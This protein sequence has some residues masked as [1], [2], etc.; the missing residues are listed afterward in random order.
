M[1]VRPLTPVSL[2]AVPWNPDQDIPST[3]NAALG[4]QLHALFDAPDPSVVPSGV[5]HWF[6]DAEFPDGVT[7]VPVVT[8]QAW[9]TYYTR[10]ESAAL[11]PGI[12]PSLVS[13]T[14]L[15]NDCRADGP[16]P[17]AIANV[18]MSVV[19][20]EFSQRVLAAAIAGTGLDPAP[21]HLAQVTQPARAFMAAPLLHAQ[22]GMDVAT[23]RSRT[24]TFVIDERFY[25]SNPGAPLPDA[26]EVD[27]GDGKPVRVV[28]FGSRITAHYPTGDS[29]AIIVRCRYGDVT[30][31]ARTSIAISDT[32]T[33]P[34]P[35]D[36]WTLTGIP[37]GNTGTAYVWRAPGHP[38]VVNPV[39]VAEGF[40]GGYPYDYIHDCFS[41]NGLLDA[42]QAR[43]YDLVV[44]SFDN[45]SDQMQHNADVMVAAIGEALT[46][47]R[48]QN[49][50][51][52]PLV[53]GGV[54]MGGLIARYAL[55]LMEAHG[56][57]HGTRLFFSIDSPHSGAYT[58]V[59][60][61][62]LLQYLAPASS[63][64]ASLAALVNSPANQ[65]FMVSWV[66]GDSAIVSPLRTLFLR[67]LEGIGSWP[68]Q[69]PRLVAIANGRG[70]GQRSIAPNA[71]MLEWSGGPFA[72]AR[73]FALP[74]G[75]EPGLVGEAYCF[76]S[77]GS[78]PSR[79]TTTSAVSWEGAPGGL[80]IYN[81][82][83]AGVAQAVGIGALND[84]IPITLCIP[85][86][87]AVGMDLDTVNAF[88]PVPPPGSGAS[89]FHDYLCGTENTRHLTITPEAS[90]FLLKHLGMPVV[91]PVPVK[92]SRPSTPKFDPASFNPHDPDFS[93][94]PYPTYRNFR[95]Y[96]PVHWVDP[97]ESYWVFRH[98]DVMRVLD[99]SENFSAL[100]FAKNRADPPS[101]PPH[102]PFD[103]MANLP[104]GLFSLDP[105]R[106][107]EVRSMMDGYLA[108]L[109]PQV[110]VIGAIIARQLL[111]SAKQSGRIELFNA[112][113]LPLPSSTLFT[114]MGT[115]QQ[116][117]MGLMSWVAGVQAGHDIT[118]PASVQGLAGTCAMALGGY[119]Q[120]LTKGSTNS[121]CP[122]HAD[123]GKL[124]DL[125]V[126]EGMGPA[127]KMS[128]EEVQATSVNLAIAGYLSTTFLIAT[129]LLD[130][131]GGVPLPGDPPTPPPS[132]LPIDLLRR[133]PQLL[134]SAINEMLRYDSPFQLTDRYVVNRPTTL[135]GVRLRIG[136][137]VTLVFGS[138]NR[139]ETVYA[140]PAVFDIT[141]QGPPHLGFGAGIHRCYGAPLV[142]AVA[143]VAFSVLLEE[144][145]SITLA[146]TPQWQTDPYIRSVTNLP[147]EVA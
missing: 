107:G 23:V 136:D 137:P 95:L 144:L 131:L 123:P 57:P 31:E 117:W 52:A 59:A 58:S 32:P 34:I 113:A 21:E 94:N 91:E 128:P 118:Q 74:E 45:G 83:A 133:N 68:H 64:A 18:A 110:P 8:Q 121:A 50:T 76:R 4:A 44:V 28:T 102:A 72:S 6:G 2:N 70:D 65:Q 60:D 3:I 105:P 143:P 122:I 98:A 69:V 40:P 42:M 54:S 10:L 134:S 17:L 51:P 127:P 9:Q 115:P 26:I 53:V 141:R 71:P 12:L 43:G 48:K 77:A 97:Y 120:G 62:W 36:E 89:P 124:F 119:F 138:A 35:D 63:L 73:L 130:L 66:S 24:V 49:G 86:L 146:G 30:L 88:A 22:F 101:P 84:D 33:A 99:D 1:P 14:Q 78:A 85:T 80:N 147:L 125:M 100:T 13:L 75:T 19:T 38:D 11:V 106:H 126:K 116:D 15:T 96:A 142:E 46:R 93:K 112:Y 92:P 129:G 27:P 25:C 61:Q 109:L 145:R 29:A 39:V 67:D 55:A 111:V 90:A 108:R 81:A 132:E 82:M 56:T 16:V 79:L 41:Q 114:L 139:D 103:V 5:L 20:P 104:E 7:S 47:A 37:S 135:G 140:N 87:S